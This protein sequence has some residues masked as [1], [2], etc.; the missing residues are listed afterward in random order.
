MAEECWVFF[1]IAKDLGYISDWTEMT[2]EEEEA[3]DDL[4]WEILEEDEQ[5]DYLTE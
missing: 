3:A 2:A 4:K 5:Q 1:K